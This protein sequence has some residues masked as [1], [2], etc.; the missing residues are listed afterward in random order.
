M[1]AQYPSVHRH[2]N[3]QYCH[4]FLLRLDLNQIDTLEA[5]LATIDAQ[6][7]ANLGPFRT[8]VELIMSIPGIKNLSALPRRLRDR[9]RY[10]PVSFGRTA[11]EPFAASPSRDGDPLSGTSGGR[12]RCA[13][14]CWGSESGGGRAAPSITGKQG[15]PE[16]GRLAS[17]GNLTGQKPSARPV[18]LPVFPKSTTMKLVAGVGFEPTTFRL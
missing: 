2:G 8:A 7:E 16:F 17:E 15:C 18:Q 11:T 10:E 1:P 5:A 6:A 13:R 12:A 9:H 14:K 3:R 4:R